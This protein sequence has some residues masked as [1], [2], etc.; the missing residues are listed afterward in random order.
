MFVSSSFDKTVRLWVQSGF[1]DD[2]K[3]V[4]FQPAGLWSA[5]SWPS[6]AVAWS[7]QPNRHFL[8]DHVG[9]SMISIATL[10]GSAYLMDASDAGQD[11]ISHA[12]AQHVLEQGQSPVRFLSRFP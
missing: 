5:Y 7:Y 1:L 2:G 10:D 11:F 12:R 9:A 8:A 4:K 6:M 3:T